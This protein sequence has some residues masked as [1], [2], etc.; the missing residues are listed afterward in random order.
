MI[1]RERRREVEGW[2]KT[3]SKKVTD[4]RQPYTAPG[5]A[6]W[7]QAANGGLGLSSRALWIRL[8]DPIRS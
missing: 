6:A 2:M 4:T 1:V 7:K 8:N 5:Q 3:L